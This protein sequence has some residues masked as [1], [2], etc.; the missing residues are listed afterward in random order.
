MDARKN[1]EDITSSKDPRTLIDSIPELSQILGVLSSLSN[2]WPA[3][4]D[5]ERKWLPGLLQ[6]RQRVQTIIDFATKLARIRE[7]EQNCQWMVRSRRTDL[8]AL[9]S[10]LDELDDRIRDVSANPSG[11]RSNVK[12][13]LS[14]VSKHSDGIRKW[15][16]EER[17]RRSDDDHR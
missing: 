4:S 17:K 1:V 11:V 5:D 3:A 10:N 14:E 7:L 12:D 13:M 8:G 9:A 6:L 16:N 2:E 15:I